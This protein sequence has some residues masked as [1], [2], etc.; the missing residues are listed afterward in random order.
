MLNEIMHRKVEKQYNVYDKA[1]KYIAEQFGKTYLEALIDA[2][3]MLFY[4]EDVLECTEEQS[5]IL[6]SILGKSQSGLSKEERRRAFQLAVLQGM[7][8]VAVPGTG[9]T[10][11][12]L[13]VT[14]VTRSPV[15][16]R[17]WNASE[18]RC[19]CA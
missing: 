12:A 5:R 13:T 14:R 4:D 2:G 9:I 7:K 8:E 18:S 17:S 3:E 10:K 1:C 16:W 19:R 11:S 15:C 6:R